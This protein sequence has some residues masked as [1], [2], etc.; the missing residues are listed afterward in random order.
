MNNF[1]FNAVYKL[2]VKSHNVV[3]ILDAKISDIGITSMPKETKSIIGQYIGPEYLTYIKEKLGKEIVYNIF[4]V[5]PSANKADMIIAFAEDGY[6]EGIDYVK[7]NITINDVIDPVKLQKVKFQTNRECCHGIYDF[8]LQK[9]AQDNKTKTMLLCKDL[10]ASDFNKALYTASCNN[11]V[12][13]M[14]LLKM[15]GA[16]RF[17]NALMIAAS[18]GHVRAST[19]LLEWGAGCYDMALTISASIGHIEVMPIF[20][21]WGANNFDDLLVSVLEKSTLQNKTEVVQLLQKWIA[22]R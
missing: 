17:N 22:E 19:I 7:S 11:C 10:G 14:S 2:F 1:L 5:I 18:R 20:K 16:S 13:A 12:E 4:G 9:A 21:R 6:K 3:V 8:I 15:W